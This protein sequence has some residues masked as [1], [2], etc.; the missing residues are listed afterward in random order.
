MVG[1]ANGQKHECIRLEVKDY[2]GAREKKA[3][4]KH[5]GMSRFRTQLGSHDIIDLSASK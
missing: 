5:S 3:F 2:L 4:V 1:E